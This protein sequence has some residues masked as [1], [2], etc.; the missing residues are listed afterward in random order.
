MALRT[1]EA[2]ERFG[3]IG[4]LMG[5]SST[6]RDISLKSGKAV[7]EALVR[8]GLDVVAIDVRTEDVEENIRLIKSKNI[9]CAFLALH[10]RFGEDGQMQE[11]L[12]ALGLPYTGSGVLASRLAM[13]K[14]ASRKIL[15]VYGLPVPRYKE[16]HRCS[17]TPEYRILPN[18]RLPLVVKPATHGSSIGISFVDNMEGLPEALEMAFRFDER[19]IVEEYIKG[20]ELTAGILDNEVLPIIEIVP[21]RRFFDYKA[22]YQSGITDYIVPARL[23]EEVTKKVKDIALRV[24]KLLGCFGCSR[25]DMILAPDNTPF[26]LEL[27]SIPGLTPVSLLPK[28]AKTVGI[29]FEQLCLKL[30]ELAYKRAQG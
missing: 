9:D 26:V 8:L 22:K 5:G 1:S 4:V 28:A 23:P 30:I 20:K 11:I 14:I 6:E 25:I 16:I 19:V 10:G 7:Y 29:E 21:K 2:P 12:D 15:E 24:H 13:D 27:N 3:R 17:F 18:L